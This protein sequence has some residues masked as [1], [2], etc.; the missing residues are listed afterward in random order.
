[1]TEPFVDAARLMAQVKGF[2]DYGFA[3]ID[4]PISSAT[5]DELR[6]RAEAAVDQAEA[7]LWSGRPAG[8]RDKLGA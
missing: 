4:H 3:V 5:D 6:R 8:S 7:L 1:M 2:P